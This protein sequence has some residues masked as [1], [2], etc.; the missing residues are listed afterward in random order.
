MKCIDW[1]KNA[2]EIPKKYFSYDKHL[3]QKLNLLRAMKQ[4]ER[5]ERFPELRDSVL[6]QK[7]IRFKK[8][9]ISKRV[10]QTGI[11]LI[12]KHNF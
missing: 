7:L 3:Q 6:A 11:K 1:T 4:I 2:V 8:C 10:H 5:F 12:T 9:F